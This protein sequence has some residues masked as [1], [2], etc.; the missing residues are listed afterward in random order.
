MKWE[1]GK[2][3]TLQWRPVQFLITQHKDIRMLQKNQ[4]KQVTTK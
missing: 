2:R 3:N 1:K 4:A